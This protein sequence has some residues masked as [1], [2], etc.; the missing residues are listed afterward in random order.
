MLSALPAFTLACTWVSVK[1]PEGYHVIG[2]TM[3]TGGPSGEM[4]RRGEL[5]GQPEPPLNFSIETHPR[6]ERFP[7]AIAHCGP[8]E[9]GWIDF[10]AKYGYLTIEMPAFKVGQVTQEG[11]NEKGFTVSLHTLR[12]SVYQKS[13]PGKK[14]LCFLDVVPFLLAQFS[15]V[16]EAVA[17]LRNITVEDPLYNVEPSG[18]L[19]HWG[20]Q[21]AS[22]ASVVVEYLKGELH[23]HNN[24]VGV[25]TNDPDFE[26]QLR[27]LNNFVA[28]QPSWPYAPKGMMVNTEIGALPSAVGHG[29]NM[30]GLPGTAS[31]PD[32]FVNM[33]Y[34]REL[35]QQ[36]MP[37]TNVADARTLV[38]ALLNRVFVIK[39]SV[40][41]AAK[42]DPTFDFTQYAVMKIPETRTF[43]YRAY[44][45]MQWK[46][47]ELSK[48]DWKKRSS[49]P[50]WQGDSGIVD[51]T[52]D[53]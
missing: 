29:F 40:A 25:M 14:S 6:G 16:D 30:L 1:S 48:I 23:V 42:D 49:V 44:D 11:M 39:G 52:S 24:T 38:T 26:W 41:R 4:S 31:P 46:A 5:A 47:I 28:V 34:L 33:F 19:G 9:G 17:A 3:E 45:N 43:I 21:D 15:T 12:Q 51:V 7:W 32:R 20:L 18:D 50:L 37:V 8:K 22:G 13:E 2:R 27:N 36:N 53:L 10:E 35:A